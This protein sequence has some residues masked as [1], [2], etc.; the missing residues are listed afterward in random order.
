M[1]KFE[2]CINALN[3]GTVWVNTYNMTP[4]LYPFGGMKQSGFGRDNAE[5]GL[6]EYTTP[7]A[8]C[9]GLDVY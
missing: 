9:Y 8:V 1:N 2:K 5:E 3:F 4:W 7:K 6:L